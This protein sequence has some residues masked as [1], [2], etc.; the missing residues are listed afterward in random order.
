[1]GGGDLKLLFLTVR[2][3]FLTE[4]TDGVEKETKGGA[5]A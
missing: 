1:M 5:D 3:L 2:T 4:K